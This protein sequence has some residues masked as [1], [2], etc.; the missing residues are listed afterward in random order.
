MTSALDVYCTSAEVRSYREAESDLFEITMMILV[1]VM[2]GRLPLEKKFSKVVIWF[3]SLCIWNVLVL[4]LLLIYYLEV[5]FLI[6][7]GKRSDL[8]LQTFF[9]EK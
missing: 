7:A 9:T 8:S 4:V 3:T 6:G 5:V 1:M 2:K